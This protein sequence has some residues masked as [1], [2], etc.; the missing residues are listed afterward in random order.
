MLAAHGAT[1]SLRAAVAA[2]SLEEVARLLGG[3]L[4]VNAPLDPQGNT[5]LMLAAWLDTPPTE[6]AWTFVQALLVQHGADPNQPNAR[7]GTPLLCACEAGHETAV[8][9]LLAAGADP[10]NVDGDGDTALCV[11]ATHGHAATVA[12]LLAHPPPPPDAS[13]SSSPLASAIDRP[14][15][16]G[17]PPLVKAAAAGHAAVVVALLGAGADPKATDAYGGAALAW[18]ARGGH[19][20]AAEALLA[21]QAPLEQADAAGTTALMLASE[22]A[23]AEV[24]TLLLSRGAA[25]DAADEAGFTAL[26]LACAVATP[27]KKSRSSMA[28]AACPHDAVI[29]RLLDAGSSPNVQDGIGRSPLM[30][31]ACNGLKQIVG[32]L[33]SRSADVHLV[34]CCGDGAL[35]LAEASCDI[36]TSVCVCVCARVGPSAVPSTGLRVY[37][38]RPSRKQSN[39]GSRSSAR[40]SSGGASRSATRSRSRLPSAGR[41]RPLPSSVRAAAR[42]S[43]GR[44]ARAGALCPM[45]TRPRWWTRAGMSTRRFDRWPRSRPWVS[46]ARALP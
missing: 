35:S 19:A 22:R 40:R 44:A 30:Y 14:G 9:A 33:L 21:M 16:G 39:S 36:Y 17:R 43:R 28:A 5:P 32:L 25:C 15:S 2:G 27:P 7:G 8:K 41:R 1:W 46:G 42:S 45:P 31:A 26:L 13:S 20:A 6:G 10:A 38:R 11:A 23:H 37:I 29:A 24:V 18:A 12:L 3:G 34:D 4:D